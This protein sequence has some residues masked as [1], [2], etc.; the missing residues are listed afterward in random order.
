[1]KRRNHR[2]LLAPQLMSWVS[3]LSV[4]LVVGGFFALVLSRELMGLFGVYL[5][6]NTA[7]FLFSYFKEDK[8]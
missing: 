7:Y 1:M 2:R 5:G 8:R 6:I 3:N 4:G